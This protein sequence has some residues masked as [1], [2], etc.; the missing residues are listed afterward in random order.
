LRADFRAT[1]SVARQFINPKPM[2]S[3][4][5]KHPFLF[6]GFSAVLGLG[7]ASAAT[8]SIDLRLSQNISD[9]NTQADPPNTKSSLGTISVTAGAFDATTASQVFTYT[10]SGLTLDSFGTA[11]DSIEFKM[12]LTGYSTTGAV[13]S[14][15]AIYAAWG[16][17]DGTGTTTLVDADEA[18]KFAFDGATVTLGAGGTE[19]ATITF[20]GFTSFQGL[21]LATSEVFDITGTTGSDQTGITGN[22]NYTVFTLT[23]PEDAFTLDVT[24]GGIRYRRIET[25]VTVD[26]VP[27]PSS[28]AVFLSLFG[29]ALIRRRR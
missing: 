13:T 5:M 4:T 7:I 11:D 27:E 26:T 21:N 29:L 9:D 8:T 12:K 25:S 28:A 6:A 10:V 18:L 24:T 19:T 3:T 22:P 16:V 1:H 17:N 15:D 23:Q 2:N 14:L 20:N